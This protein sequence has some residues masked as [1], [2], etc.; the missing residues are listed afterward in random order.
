MIF[1]LGGVT[2]GGGLEGSGREEGD[3]ERRREGRGREG[4]G[5]GIGGEVPITMEPLAENIP[6][7]E[8]HNFLRLLCS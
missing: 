6:D 4:R 1:Q 5:G 8:R 7:K 2:H 3:E